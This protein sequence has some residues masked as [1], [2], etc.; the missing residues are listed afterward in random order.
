MIG[1]P[2]VYR[3]YD[4]ADRAALIVD[5][6]PTGVGP[7]GVVTLVAFGRQAFE[8]VMGGMQLMP[9]VS[10]LSNV[11]PAPPGVSGGAVPPGS[12]RPVE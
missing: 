3:S 9:G 2:V 11:P 4:G 7:D 8:Q 10:Y 6:N 1:H 12:W 5:D